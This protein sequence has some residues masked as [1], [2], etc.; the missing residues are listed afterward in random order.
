[1]DNEIKEVVKM[2]RGTLLT[3]LFFILL[4]LS[5]CSESHSVLTLERN[6][7]VSYEYSFGLMQVVY[8]AARSNEEDPFGTIKKKLAEEGF[9][10]TDYEKEGVQGFTARQEYSSLESLRSS[11]E[12]N[13]GRLGASLDV[14]T[15]KGLFKST[16]A[17]SIKT[18]FSSVGDELVT[19]DQAEGF[20]PENFT[21][22]MDYTYTIRLP[23]KVLSHNASQVDEE[24]GLYTWKLDPFS[25]NTLELTYTKVQRG[26]WILL[27]VLLAGVMTL[28]LYLLWK[29]RIISFQKEPRFIKK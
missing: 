25:E 9:Q 29:A 4:I 28:L 13:K 10:V 22:N 2:K 6:G 16:I 23:F 12:K 1:M 8:E 5:A 7:K 21:K 15:E 26:V 3:L 17:L 27:A 19:N 20:L 18:D 14:V 24:E 11:L